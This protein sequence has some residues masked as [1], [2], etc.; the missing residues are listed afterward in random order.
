VNGET[1]VF[2]PPAWALE[3]CTPSVDTPMRARK[4]LSFEDT[5]KPRLGEIAKYLKQN[6]WAWPTDPS[7]EEAPLQARM[8]TRLETMNEGEGFDA[9]LEAYTFLL[10]RSVSVWPLE[11]VPLASRVLAHWTARTDAVTALTTLMRS[12]R[13]SCFAEQ[14]Y[15]TLRVGHMDTTD[16]GGGSPAAIREHVR[17]YGRATLEATVRE[18]YG[19]RALRCWI[20]DDEEDAPLALAELREKAPTAMPAMLVA[21]LPS[22]SDTGPLLSSASMEDAMR[23][24]ARHGIELAEAVL[25]LE[26]A[27]RERA[28]YWS[29]YPSLAAAR[30]LVASLESKV[31]RK[32]VGDA[33]AHMPEHALIALSEAKSKKTKYRD[34]IDALIS[35]LSAST[36]SEEQALLEEA[37]DAALPRVLVSPPWHQKKRAKLPT[38]PG[39]VAR[40]VEHAVDLSSIDPKTLAR[41]R[42]QLSRRYTAQQ[43]LDHLAA[44]RGVDAYAIA[45][46]PFEE[47]EVLRIENALSKISGKYWAHDTYMTGLTVLLDRDGPQLIPALLQLAPALQARLACEL[48][49][50]GAV[51]IAELAVDWLRSKSARKAAGEWVRRFP[52]HA[53]A[54]LLP[55]VLGADTKLPERDRALTLFALL[56]E[57]RAIVLEEAAVHGADVVSA[58][59]ALLD[60]DPLENAPSKAPKVLD[61]VETLPRVT[62]K[63]GRALPRAAQLHLIEMLAFSPIDAPY[64]GLEQAAEACDPGSLDR[65]VEGLVRLWVASGM[66]SAHE[67][68]PRSVA[69]IGS[70]RAARFL[71]DRGR[72]WAQDSQ[73][74][75]ALLTLDVLGAMGTDLALSL[76]GRMSRS[77]QRQ[78]LKDRATEILAEI[79]ET[80][81]LSADELEDRTA[82]DLELD[83]QGTLVL[84][85]G[86]RNFRVGFDEHL[87]PFARTESGERLDVLPRANKADDAAK[88]KSAWDAWKLLRSEAERVAK[89]QIAR[90]ERMMADERRIAP[91]IFQDCFVAHPLV[92]H[93]A[94]RLIWGA[95]D[96][97]GTLSSTFRIAEDRSLANSDDDPIT[98]P[99]DASV[100][101][102]HPLHLNEGTLARWSEVLGDYTL[103]QPFGQLARPRTVLDDASLLARYAHAKAPTGML[104]SLRTSGWRT[105]VGEYAEIEAFHREVGGTRYHLALSPAMVQGQPSTVHTISLSSSSEAGAEGPTAVQRAELAFQLDGVLAR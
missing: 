92:G 77:G 37:P 43:A 29:C 85:F 1:V 48:S 54:G 59:T 42:K 102:V 6:R 75:R 21:L 32:V 100:G 78:Y 96:A 82:P 62:L 47:L 99:D 91:E 66:P 93:L 9:E 41:E 80:R 24:I 87:M 67:W 72:A 10:A 98:L 34:A 97:K 23:A 58:T 44:G 64:V 90:L 86:P 3:E 45:H 50:A 103:V 5:W 36:S 65:F 57:H 30:K 69:L 18:H 11:S 40:D 39:L 49:Y 15:R 20:L 63:D 52:R 105:S 88:A 4:A 56:S 14:N 76:V 17:Q 31:T 35:T 46:L 68:A 27:F 33:L 70:D 25:A 101:V 16:H 89:D 95:F 7:P 2:A 104:Y 38:F 60:R 26:G 53:A 84:D 51:E 61:G 79:A 73:K 19:Q 55:I 71:F 12:L 8:R 74:Q 83:E 81:G 28:I 22:P 94:T 13:L